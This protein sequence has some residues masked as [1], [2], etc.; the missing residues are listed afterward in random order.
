MFPGSL[1]ARPLLP[2]PPSGGNLVRKPVIRRMSDHSGRRASRPR[3]EVI[4][5]GEI[6]ALAM[7][8]TLPRIGGIATLPSPVHTLPAALSLILPQVD[9]LFVFFDK[10]AS[11]PAPFL[12]HPKIGPQL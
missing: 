6:V 8:E 10:S 3:A 11:V 4:A 9:R 2:M 5:T 7:S 12:G 1:R